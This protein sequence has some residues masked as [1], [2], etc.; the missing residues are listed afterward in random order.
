MIKI[1]NDTS[2]SL[3][4]VLYVKYGR[5]TLEKGTQAY[6][7]MRERNNKAIHKHRQKKRDEMK[8]K[9]NIKSSKNCLNKAESK[10]NSE[11]EKKPA[12]NNASSDENIRFIE[13]EY[14]VI[15]RYF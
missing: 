3:D 13:H 5:R 12:L 8:M 4:S 2:S 9:S 10:I 14:P 6:Y 7:E 11:E 1:E 15:K